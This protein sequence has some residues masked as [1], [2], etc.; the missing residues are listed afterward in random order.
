MASTVLA[1]ATLA[2]SVA[3]EVPDTV[4]LLDPASE[5]WRLCDPA[6]AV[7]SFLYGNPGDLPM[8][9]DWDCDGVDPPGLDHRADGSFVFATRTAIIGWVRRSGCDVRPADP[10]TGYFAETGDMSCSAGSSER[11]RTPGPGSPHF[12]REVGIPLVNRGLIRKVQ[13]RRPR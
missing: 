13:G 4:G 8:M 12:P 10:G 6:G 1:V 7:T 3:A 2:G 9:G 11:E 5:E